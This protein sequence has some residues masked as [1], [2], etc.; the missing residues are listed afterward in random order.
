MLNE[1]MESITEYIVIYYHL[2]SSCCKATLKTM[3]DRR[4]CIWVTIG[5]CNIVT[6]QSFEKRIKPIYKTD[7]LF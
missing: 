6:G 1:V 7:V 5:C 3:N 4:D 2:L